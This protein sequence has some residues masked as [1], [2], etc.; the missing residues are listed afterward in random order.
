MLRG[1]KVTNYLLEKSRVVRQARGERCFHVMHYLLQGANAYE[2][3]EYRLLPARYGRQFWLSKL[4][5]FFFLCAL[6][7]VI[8]WC[9]RYLFSGNTP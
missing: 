7:G 3:S 5:I 9:R 4:K 1:G 2:R 8:C 6:F